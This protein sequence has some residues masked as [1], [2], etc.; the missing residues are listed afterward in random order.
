MVCG[1]PRSPRLRHAPLARVRR[2]EFSA[3]PAPGT[4]SWDSGGN[5]MAIA[6]HEG[7]L[8]RKPRISDATLHD[9]PHM[10][11]RPY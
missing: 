3:E 11:C 5:V 7:G 9:F 2:R 8:P 10:A 6:E 1:A 4:V